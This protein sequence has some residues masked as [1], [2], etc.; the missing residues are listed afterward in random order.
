MWLIYMCSKEPEDSLL[1]SRCRN[2]G[3][4]FPTARMAGGCCGSQGGRPVADAA[5]LLPPFYY[6]RAPAAGVRAFIEAAL[7]HAKLPV[8]Y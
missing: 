1:L 8:C 6:E 2:S 7:A 5:L 3:R 4:G